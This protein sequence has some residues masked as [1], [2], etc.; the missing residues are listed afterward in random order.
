MKRA[1]TKAKLCEND[2]MDIAICAAVGVLA[3][4][5]GGLFGIGGG[6]VVVPALV[7]LAGFTQ[8]KAQGTSLAA[9][10]APVGILGALTYAKVGGVEWK[11][12]A[13]IAV[14][15]ILG[16]YGGAKVAIVLDELLM[17]RLF[18]AFLVLIAVQLALKK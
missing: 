16:A 5:F 8:Q 10:L 12:A 4:I 6:V 11:S 13:I 14:G 7:Y 15:F 9:L 2:G 17:R 3:G 1:Y 18:A